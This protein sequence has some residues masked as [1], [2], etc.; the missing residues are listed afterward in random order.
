VQ[1]ALRSVSTYVDV[2]HFRNK[3]RKD[4][5]IDWPNSRCPGSACDNVQYPP[6]VYTGAPGQGTCAS[7]HGM[8]ISGS[9]VTVAAPSTYTPGGAAVSM[10][11]TI[12]STGGFELTTL[13]QSNNSQAGT[14]AAGPALAGSAFPQDA[15]STVGTIQYVYSTVETT[16][17]TVVLDPASSKC[18]QC[19]CV[20]D[21]WR[22]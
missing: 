5:D 3:G 11:V 17:W 13:A 12:P 15:V 19:R 2:T 4:R 22:P 10:T 1:S 16:S 21:W 14:L 7:C 8:L 18:W 9:G 6:L 20:R